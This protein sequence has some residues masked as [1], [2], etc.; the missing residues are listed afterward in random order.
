MH[1]EQNL[2]VP[3]VQKSFDRPEAFTS[4][5]PSLREM[6]SEDCVLNFSRVNL[7][8]WA[9]TSGK[10]SDTTVFNPCPFF[11]AFLDRSRC[12]APPGKLFFQFLQFL[13]DL[14]SFQEISQHGV[15]NRPLNRFGPS[16]G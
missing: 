12:P 13:T 5:C 3:I 9:R 11:I 6:A 1:V 8:L 10:K 4:S 7:T 16:F 14:L 2:G 15:S